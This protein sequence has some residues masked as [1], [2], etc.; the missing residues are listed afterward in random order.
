MTLGEKQRL[1]MSLIPRLIDYLYEQ[2]YEASLGD[3]YRDPRVFG[4]QGESKGYGHRNSNHKVRL[5]ID[6]NLFKD[7]L[8]L[9]NT[10]DHRF[11]GEYWE[12]LH[13]FAVWGGRFS[14][15]DGN[16]YSFENEGY[17]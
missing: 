17:M 14:N 15:P 1:F 9:T 12:S 4:K 5:A 2:G 13:R 10:E 3:G 7:G 16:H 6:I 11:L 8:Y